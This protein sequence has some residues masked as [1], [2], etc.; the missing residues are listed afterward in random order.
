MTR[1]AM[2]IG[3]IGTVIGVIPQL[4]WTPPQPGYLRAIDSTGGQPCEGWALAV[5]GERREPDGTGTVQYPA[6]WH[7]RSAHVFLKHNRLVAVEVI[8]HRELLM[9]ACHAVAIQRPS[10]PTRG[11]R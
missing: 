3:I 11:Q 6:A 8:G 4:R 9:L 7:G 10:S 2:W 1:F 5:G